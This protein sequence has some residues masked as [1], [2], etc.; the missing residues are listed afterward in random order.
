[1]LCAFDH[2][3]APSEA[4]ST[5]LSFTQI[6]TWNSTKGAMM[7][8]DILSNRITPSSGETVEGKQLAVV[9]LEVKEKVLVCE[10]WEKC[11]VELNGKA[12]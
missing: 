3:S 1:M 2:T 6:G 9:V 4:L 10:I 11:Y 7:S 8:R 5:W 12:V